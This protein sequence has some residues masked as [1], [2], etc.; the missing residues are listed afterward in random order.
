[1]F[2]ASDL[3]CFHNK[4]V[5]EAL[6]V[7]GIMNTKRQP[8]HLPWKDWSD[9]SEIAQVISNHNQLEKLNIVSRAK[10]GVVIM[11]SIQDHCEYIETLRHPAISAMQIM[12]FSRYYTQ[13]RASS[14]S[15]SKT[16]MSFFAM[17]Y[18]CIQP[19]SFTPAG[20]KLS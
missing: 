6:D 10:A 20:C 19:S 14:V 11:A 1:M 13:S 8:E 3:S 17:I 5:D 18:R 7:L 2:R 9:D 16:I 4:T 12:M 15:K